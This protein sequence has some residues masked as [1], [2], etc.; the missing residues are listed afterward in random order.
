MR[1]P[2]CDRRDL[3]KWATGLGLS[4]ALPGLDLRAASRRGEK[5]P[6]SLITLWLSG[7]PSQLETWDPHPQTKIGGPTQAIPTSIP[8]VRIASTY[9][10]LA[11]QM[12]HLSVIRSLVSKEGD[13]DRASYLV[14]TGFRPDPTLRHPSVGAIVAHALPNEQLQI[15]PVISLGYA[16]HLSR[17]G[18]LGGRFDALRIHEPGSPGTDMKTWLAEPRQQQRL[19]NLDVVAQAFT[20]G[21]KVVVDRT[22]HAD[23]IDAA[24]KMMNSDQ[25][26][27]FQLDDETESTRAAYG[28]SNFSRGCL[29]ARRLIEQGVRAVEV[30]LQNFDTHDNNFGRHT[31][32]A[33]ELDSPFATLLKDLHNRDLLASTVVLCLGEFGRTP[34]ING[35]DGRDHWPQGFSCLVG[36][37]SMRSGVLIGATDP[38]GERDTPEDPVSV[39]DLYAT[40][41]KGLGIDCKHQINTSIGRPIRYSDGTPIDR[42]L[43]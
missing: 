4:F 43:I 34:R 37:G 20:R 38:T 21:R 18:F 5:R 12:H 28:D 6:R 41:L 16:N 30:T 13:H 7:G 31:E 23:N 22:M 26:K 19:S 25:M 3:L 11:E 17:G 14:K 15:P 24:L 27:A 32:L 9:P 8:N 1:Q 36:G 2:S 40:V 29:V 33:T 35:A 10:R 42:L 39:Q